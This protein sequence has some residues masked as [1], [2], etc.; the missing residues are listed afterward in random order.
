MSLYGALFT[1]VS[2]LNAQGQ[3][4]AIISDNISNVNTVG[5]K[6][7]QAQFQTLVVNS[8]AQA[9]YSPGG[10]R[11]T[12]RINVDKQGIIQSTSAPTDIAISGKGFFAVNS[13][14]DSSS[15]ML[16]S[17]AGS[18]RQDSTGNFV[19]S[20]GFFLQ[21]WPLDR[22]GNLP[23]AP[24]NLNTISSANLE[25]LQTVNVENSGGTANATTE[26]RLGVNLNAGQAVQ[27]GAGA[28][29][30]MDT[31]STE[32]RLLAADQIIV[33][34]ETNATAPSFGLSPLNNLTRGDRFTVTTGGGLNYD[35][36]Y[37]GFTIGRNVNNADLAA[38]IG[39]AGNDISPIA[40]D[41]AAA[42][43]GITLNSGDSFYT[44]DI[45]TDASALGLVAGSR[46]RLNNVTMSNTLGIP[47]SEFN[48]IVTVQSVSAGPGTTFTVA[49]SVAAGVGGP[50][51]E[52]AGSFN[53]RLFSGNIFDAT[54]VNQPFF[55]STTNL[56][57]YTAAARSFT[58]S[59]ASVPNGTVTFTY[60]AS[61]PNTQS[62][63]FNSLATLAEAINN[64]AG[65]TAR[66]SGTSVSSGRLVVG[67]ENANEAVTFNN[68]DA[69]GNTTLS[70]LNWIQELDLR[71]ITT[72]NRVFSTMQGLANIVNSDAGLSA[73]IT[74]P[75]SDSTLN[76]FNDDPLDTIRFQDFA[77][78]AVNLPANPISAIANF[79]AGPP[80]TV[81][82]TVDLV[83]HTFNLGDNVV[84]G[85]LTDITNGGETLT[86]AELNRSHQ[87]VAPVVAGTSFT[88]RVQT[89]A[90]AAIAGGTGGGAAGTAQSTN[91]G[92][93][94][95]ELGIVAS[96]NG[97][98]YTR[99]DTGNLGPVYDASAVTGK[100][101]ASGDIT[102]HF[103][104]T[105][106]VYDPLGDGHDLRVAF[107]KIG[108]NKWAVEVFGINP[109]EISTTR[110]DGIVA[111]GIIEFNGDASLKN[112]SSELL[113]PININWT[114][115]A[116]SNTINLNLGNAGFPAGTVGATIIG[117]T[118]GMSQFEGRYNV[119]FITQNGAP[120]GE[121]VGVTIDKEGFV[122]ASFTNGETKKLYKVPIAD[123]ANPNGL[124]AISGNVFAQTNAS[125][126]V[127]LR[128]AGQ[129]GAGDV[130]SNA[131][132]ASNV[133]LAE[134]LTDMIVA[135]RAY[136]SNTR[137]ITTTDELLERLTQ[138]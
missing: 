119:A 77:A 6:E 49:T 118:S 42:G 1:G 38:N 75:L 98:T 79:L 87:V 63:Q 96:L 127:N 46:I 113:N 84:L 80:Q 3:K 33:P 130:V 78:P 29:I 26:L 30:T 135:Q 95:A 41:G 18:F 120:V 5:Y 114:N 129:N 138:I 122:I 23:G 10:V 82:V 2:G 97:A 72:G 21:G 14:S 86:A 45:G 51:N 16:Y 83:G 128:E 59:N 104:R 43:T 73:T 22:N 39:D 55:S 106:T 12:T 93:I 111:A 48:G 54:G 61:S 116:A 110:P 101:M 8:T 57:D 19:N 7:G 123:F 65:L 102:A 58:I 37:G 24:G 64:T 105:V 117:D 56:G 85:G 88:V 112:V 62:G 34:D 28:N 13:S 31:L 66:I 126:N 107:L 109:S 132:E 108:E 36:T 100:N 76:I 91:Q 69:N 53:T 68:V 50:A 70:G 32:N 17:R 124:R 9:S 71:D 137:V 133:D 35:Y 90:L 67:A 44:V 40:F 125:G 52:T 15:Q 94:L 92:S 131:L 4:I 134:Q 89:A 11:N 115:G 27:Q 99:G 74:N 47:I 121:L 60:T 81:D 103:S 20:Q 25:S 136:Q